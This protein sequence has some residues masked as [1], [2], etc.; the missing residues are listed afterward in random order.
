MESENKRVGAEDG[1]ESVLVFS[2]LPSGCPLGCLD[3]L[4]DLHIDRKGVQIIELAMSSVLVGV[5]R[6]ASCC[7]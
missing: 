3:I 5:F 7:R 1:I 4:L 6:L 2:W